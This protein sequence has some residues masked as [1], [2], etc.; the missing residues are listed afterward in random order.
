MS[1]GP[2]GFT[3]KPSQF[4]EADAD[5]LAE[6]NE[7]VKKV[8]EN[9]ASVKFLPFQQKISELVK[10]NIP[11]KHPDFKPH[12]TMKNRIA[13][14]FKFMIGQ[15]SEI[16]T[17]T[18]QSMKNKES[19]L[20]SKID[21][22]REE[23]AEEKVIEEL[24]RKL[25]NISRQR[26]EAEK[27]KE[28]L[29]G[30]Q[31]ELLRQAKEEHKKE[32]S[33]LQAQSKDLQDQLNQTESEKKSLSEK[34][35]EQKGILDKKEQEVQN[36]KTERDRIAGELTK[37]KEGTPEEAKLQE[38]LAELQTKITDQTT[39]IQNKAQEVDNLK[40][41]IGELGAKHD[42]AQRAKEELESMLEE[43]QEK[44]ETKDLAITKRDKTIELL[45]FVSGGVLDKIADEFKRRAGEKPTLQPLIAKNIIKTIVFGDLTSKDIDDTK[46]EEY[47]IQ[48]MPMVEKRSGIRIPKKEESKEEK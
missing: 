44:L 12:S 33:E 14:L 43:A 24:Q 23:G 28:L 31:E 8:I 20:R 32:L 7:T 22:L 18:I 45:S 10:K 9:L 34:I 3:D 40:V 6:E 35:E 1:E 41:Q 15:K 17:A 25:S 37:V 30:Q 38:D 48:L 26:D 46:L 2:L 27:S 19:E 5:K 42:E 29:E 4:T 39:E 36:L 47:I 11:P 13:R 21:K 16:E